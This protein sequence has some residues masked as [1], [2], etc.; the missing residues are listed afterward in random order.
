MILKHSFRTPCPF[1]YSDDSAAWKQGLANTLSATTG[2]EIQLRDAQVDAWN[3][4]ENDQVGLLLGPPGTGKTLT[5]SAMSCGL[6]GYCQQMDRPCRI[7]ITGFTR[8]SIENV[9][10]YIA[11]FS[12]Q[13]PGLQFE[14]AY[15]KDHDDSD[16]LSVDPTTFA[17]FHASHEHSVYGGTI[18]TLF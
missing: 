1:G 8:N 9:L 18:W 17:D 5:V 12:K 11:S 13:Y 10:E 6:F 4:M 3:N 2:Q 15:D 7:F 16:I 14:L